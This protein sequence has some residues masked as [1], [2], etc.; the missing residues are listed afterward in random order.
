MPQFTCFLWDCRCSVAK[1]CRILGNPTHCSTPGFPVFCY[2]LKLAHTHVH[3]VGD[4]I[5]PSRPLGLFDDKSAYT[6]YDGDFRL[7]L[8][9]AQASP[10]FHSS[11]EGKLGTIY[12][13]QFMRS[14]PIK[15]I[16]DISRSERSSNFYLHSYLVWKGTKTALLTKKW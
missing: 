1:W 9:L 15:K 8:V 11:C 10:I 13:Q 6:S 5:Q 16:T 7:P 12:V 3:C 14:K 2:F 4:A